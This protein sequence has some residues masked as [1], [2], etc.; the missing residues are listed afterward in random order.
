MNNNKLNLLLHLFC[1]LKISDHNT[2][3]SVPSSSS[4]SWQ[5][6]QSQEI[7][8]PLLSSTPQHTVTEMKGHNKENEEV[9]LMSSDSSDSSSSVD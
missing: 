6:S 2:A 7:P 3:S 5:S 8:V 4:L 9:E 1:I